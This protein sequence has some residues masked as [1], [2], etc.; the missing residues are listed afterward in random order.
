VVVGEPPQRSDEAR[1]VFMDSYARAV[2]PKEERD[3]KNGVAPIKNGMAPIMARTQ[4]KIG[5]E[6]WRLD[7]LGSPKVPGRTR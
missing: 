4:K 6:Q 2:T 3:A 7:A 5:L 1:W